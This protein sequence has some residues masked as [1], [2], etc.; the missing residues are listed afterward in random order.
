MRALGIA[1]RRPR[2]DRARNEPVP[3]RRS[4]VDAAASRRPDDAGVAPPVVRLS[5][6]C[7]IIAAGHPPT[8]YARHDHASIRPPDHGWPVRRRTRHAHRAAP[9]HGPRSLLRRRIR[10][11]DQRVDARAAS[12]TAVTPAPRRTSS[13]PAARSASA[14]GSRTNCSHR[15]VDAF[16]RGETEEAQTPPDVRR[17][18]RRTARGGAVVPRAPGPARPARVGR[19]EA[20]PE[21]PPARRS[22]APTSPRPRAPPPAWALP[23]RRSS[24]SSWS[25]CSTSRRRTSAPRRSCSCS[26]GAER[27]ATSASAAGG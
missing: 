2:G 26:T 4:G 7:P 1:A 10:A 22:D 21:G 25:C 3:L 23:V 19:A 11:G 18:A 17:R 24:A 14:S 20:R 16:N 9:A 6:D 5:R 13:G 27:D 15:G 12:S 8:D